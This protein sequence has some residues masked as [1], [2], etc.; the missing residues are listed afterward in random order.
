L[1]ISTIQTHLSRYFHF[2]VNFPRATPG[3]ILVVDH[4]SRP[5]QKGVYRI[6]RKASFA[7][8]KPIVE[9]PKV[10]THYTG[11][12]GENAV[13]SELLFWGFNA[14]KQFQEREGH[15]LVKRGDKENG[16]NLGSWISNQRT[17][18]DNLTPERRQWLDAIGFV[19]HVRLPRTAND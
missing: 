11:A 2:A 4:Q 18:K 3:R 13:M 10:T 7:I 19:W 1:V 5:A 12:A 16:V 8:H 9:T 15:F 6:R 17:K 14:L